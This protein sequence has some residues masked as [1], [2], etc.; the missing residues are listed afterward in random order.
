MKYLTLKSGNAK[1]GEMSAT[2]LPI[3][4]TCPAACPLKGAG[5]YAQGGN[6][7]MI[8]RKKERHADEH[9]LRALALVKAEA[10]E[11]R[12]AGPSAGGR[13]LRLHVSGDA[14]TDA[15]ARALRNAREHWNG[16]VYTYT[17][18]WRTVARMSWG[19]VSVLASCESLA[20]AA[21]ALERG[22]APAMAV[23]EHKSDRAT[24][25]PSTGIRVIPCPSQ[26]RGVTCA[27]CKLCMRD[28]ALHAG[29]A[30][31][32]FAAHGQDKKRALRV[33]Q[34]TS[35]ATAMPG[36]VGT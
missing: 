8:Q 17:H 9:G 27:Q 23:P 2:Y 12:A 1:I 31:I 22:Y 29:R 14:R 19:R 4:Q 5:C 20:E 18:A 33:L 11:I 16:P 25:D 21:N 30:V 3:K 6:V 24:V 7:G 10:A 15:S 26:T 32:A 36:M 34:N 28:E 35:N 13:A